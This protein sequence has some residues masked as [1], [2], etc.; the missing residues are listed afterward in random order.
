MRPLAKLLQSSF[1]MR[2]IF[3]LTL[4][5]AI[6]ITLASVTD[7]SDSNHHRERRYIP[8]PT[9]L[10]YSIPL[11]L[12][13]AYSSGGGSGGSG[14][15]SHIDPNIGMSAANIN[16]MATRASM[17]GPLSLLGALTILASL[18]L[19]TKYYQARHAKQNVLYYKY[20]DH[21]RPYYIKKRSSLDKDLDAMVSLFNS[22]W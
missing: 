6:A 21:S 13:L 20:Y 22:F 18:A 11:A 12:G 9:E 17:A 7:R 4:M 8:G 3:N 16:S 10:K 2:T 19:A 15:P 1:Q 5:A 14:L